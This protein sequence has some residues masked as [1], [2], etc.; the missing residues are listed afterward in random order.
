MKKDEFAVFTSV[1][2]PFHRRTLKS[3]K[4]ILKKI[5][6]IVSRGEEEGVMVVCREKKEEEKS[7]QIIGE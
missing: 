6:E 3:G 7:A 5:D 4:R 2:S 1:S